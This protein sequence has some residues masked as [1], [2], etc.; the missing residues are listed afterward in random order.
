MVGELASKNESVHLQQEQ[1]GK[2]QY[3]ITFHRLTAH[4]NIS[5]MT[6]SQPKLSNPNEKLKVSRDLKH[7]FFVLR[8]NS[9]NNREKRCFKLTEN[10][11]QVIAV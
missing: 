2:A 7:Q 1:G 8:G 5:T 3:P 10:Y 11:T 9:V 6:V 4:K